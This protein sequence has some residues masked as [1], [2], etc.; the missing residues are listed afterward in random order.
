MNN[1]E[2]SGETIFQIIT[3]FVAMKTSGQI[4]PNLE[5]I[6][7]RSPQSAVDGPIRP[8]FKLVRALMNGI[9]TC[10]YEKER[11][12]NSRGKSGDTVFFQAQPYLLPWKPVVG[13]GQILN[14]SK[15]SC[16]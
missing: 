12:K 9:V 6:Q 15:L 14:S 10:K 4:W 7:A 5:I 2:K 11:L 3:L 16:M 8:K 13:S 1:Q